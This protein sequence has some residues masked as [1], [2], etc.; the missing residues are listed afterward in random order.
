MSGGDLDAVLAALEA[1]HVAGAAQVRAARLPL[2]K[3]AGVLCKVNPPR[4]NKHLDAMLRAVHQF[5]LTRRQA[6]ALLLRVHGADGGSAA[7]LAA[8]A[9][10][11]YR[12]TLRGALAHDVLTN[13]A[14]W[15]L[16]AA[17]ALLAGLIAA[18]LTCRYYPSGARLLSMPLVCAALAAAE[19][20]VFLAAKFAVLAV[21]LAALWSARALALVAAKYA[22][23]KAAARLT[24]ARPYARL[25]AA[26]ALVAAGVVAGLYAPYMHVV[27]A[28][29]AAYALRR[30][31]APEND[32]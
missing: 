14:H 16:L 4:H 13:R 12:G 5:S 32:P 17:V 21:A 3:A 11:A 26:A 1:A 15:L 2:S 20:F 24:A 31:Q 29:G 23:G 28:C 8:R 30:S 6:C 22:R 7:A 19:P 27:G 10:E 25:A 9:R 18:K